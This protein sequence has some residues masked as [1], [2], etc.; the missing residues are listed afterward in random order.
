[1]SL[2]HFSIKS[3]NAAGPFSPF[4]RI[5]SSGSLPLGTVRILIGSPAFRKMSIAL[6][7]AF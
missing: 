5:N 3:L 1:M 2:P 6:A 4:E 7:V